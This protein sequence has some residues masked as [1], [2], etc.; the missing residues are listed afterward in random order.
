MRIAMEPDRVKELQ[1]HSNIL[2]GILFYI[3]LC[4]SWQGGT[5]CVKKA[6]GLGRTIFPAEWSGVGCFK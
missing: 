4:V 5:E 1:A 2:F 6:T 3:F